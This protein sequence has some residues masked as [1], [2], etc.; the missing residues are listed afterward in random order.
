MIDHV[1][2]NLVAILKKYYLRKSI[3]NVWVEKGLKK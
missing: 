1:E 2:I 3:G